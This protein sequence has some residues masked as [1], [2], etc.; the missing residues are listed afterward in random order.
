MK[1]DKANPGVKKA[2]EDMLDLCK[3]LVKE[4]SLLPSIIKS[5]ALRIEVC[6][7]LSLT[8]IMIKKIKSGDVL[9]K[10][11]KLSGFDWLRALCNGIVSG[12]FCKKKSL[13]TKVKH[14]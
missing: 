11:I 13:S 7:I 10:H 12:V 14:E 5:T 9:Q 2:I 6:V 8:N 3:G 1:K 4:G